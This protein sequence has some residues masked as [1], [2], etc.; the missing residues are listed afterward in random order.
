VVGV[1]LSVI[2]SLTVTFTSQGATG[3]LTSSGIEG[4]KC[5]VGTG[6][7]SSKG[8]EEEEEEEEEEKEPRVSHAPIISS[9]LNCLHFL[10]KAI[11]F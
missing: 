2:S 5:E 6:L 4:W 7:A 8:E 3:P 10:N 1:I 9:S 11:F